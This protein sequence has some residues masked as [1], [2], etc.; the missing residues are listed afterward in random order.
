MRA[1]DAPPLSRRRAPQ[2]AKVA[3][4]PPKGRPKAGGGVGAAKKGAKSKKGAARGKED[5]EAVVKKT[6]KPSTVMWRVSD[7]LAAV[8]GSN[9]ATVD[10]IRTG[11]YGYIK[12]HNLQVCP[13]SLAWRSV[14]GKLKAHAS[15]LAAL[16]AA[17]SCACSRFRVATA[18]VARNVLV[19]FFSSGVAPVISPRRLGA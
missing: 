1:R 11:V 17:G 13:G 7:E 8:V 16:T 5:G 10:T 2:K 14:C 19:L 3:S 18:Q 6:R 4:T 9:E 12:E 15:I